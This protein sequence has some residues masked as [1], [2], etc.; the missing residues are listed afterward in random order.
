MARVVEHLAARVEDL[1]EVARVGHARAEG[2]LEAALE[3]LLPDQ[4]ELL[5]D[6]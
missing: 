5:M 6:G 1:A 2:D 4:F 3:Q